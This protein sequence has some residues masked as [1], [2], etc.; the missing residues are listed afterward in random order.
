MM[1]QRRPT[2]LDRC[3][4]TWSRWTLRAKPATI[5]D[6][7]T[8]GVAVLDHEDRRCE[9]GRV[10]ITTSALSLHRTGDGRAVFKLRRSGGSA[11]AMLSRWRW[12][13]AIF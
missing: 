13:V 7:L 5:L 9:P 1:T 6:N 2:L 11:V 8:T 3:N 12:P 10:R 4:A